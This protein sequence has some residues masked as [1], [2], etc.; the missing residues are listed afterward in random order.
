MS[1]HFPPRTSQ[2]APIQTRVRLRFDDLEDFEVR[3]CEN[4]SLGGLFIRTT[5]PPPVGTRV[6]FE[7]TL[8]DATEL[9]RGT[10]EVMWIRHETLDADN[11]A[12]MGVRFIDLSPGSRAIIFHAVD[13]H[14]QEGGQPFNLSSEVQHAPRHVTAAAA[15]TGFRPAVPPA[16]E[17]PAEAADLAEPARPA[18]STQ[19]QPLHGERDARPH[20]VPGTGAPGTGAGKGVATASLFDTEP[21]EP[22][23]ATPPG[24]S[25]TALHSPSPRRGARHL[26]GSASATRG[27][28]GPPVARIA[29]L[30]VVLVA[31]LAAGWWWLGQ[32][33]DDGAGP[34]AG[35]APAGL[36]TGRRGTERLG[37]PR[38]AARE[39]EDPATLDTGEIPTAPGTALLPP[40]GDAQL[41]PSEVDE[42]AEGT[43]AAG[44]GGDATAPPPATGEPLSLLEEISWQRTD[45]GTE[46]VLRG[47]GLFLP[48]SYTHT[49]L[50]GGNPRELI[51]LRGIRRP[52]RGGSVAVGS[53]E[54]RQVRTGYHANEEL[55]VV[56]DLADGGVGQAQ[57]VADGET[58]T[59]RLPARSGG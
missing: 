58:L 57:V 39:P 31:L 13:R 35:T 9:I 48:N 21:A 8:T 22:A 18:D 44:A 43:D 41:P 25:V 24:D 2:R 49:P 56:L 55:H 17:Q 51:R 29:A 53:P 28:S 10:G 32:R 36:D 16:P 20:S 40:A 1:E 30:A 54:L 12:G 33:G 27:P 5:E 50:R 23:P 7:F 11:Q 46:V 47:E 52:Y 42:I 4:L 59:I 3:Q 14:I 38:R 45:D 37:E 26:S 19:Q 15:P 6:D 34:A